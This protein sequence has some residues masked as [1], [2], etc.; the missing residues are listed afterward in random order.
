MQPTLNPDTCSRR[1][2]GLFSINPVKYAKTY[3]RWDIVSLTSPRDPEKTLIKRII[4]LGGDTVQTLAPY[5]DKEVVVPENHVWIEGDEHFVSDDSNHFGPVS[6]LS[7]SY[8]ALLT[9]TREKIPAG[10]MQGKLVALI[11]PPERFGR[12]K[13]ASELT[14]DDSRMKKSA[15]MTEIRKEQLRQARVKV[16]EPESNQLL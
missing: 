14:E 1:D 10:L 2:V 9:L 4:A 3:Q 7:L 13:R 15:I 16:A 5:P 12:I 6:S 8:I 11:W